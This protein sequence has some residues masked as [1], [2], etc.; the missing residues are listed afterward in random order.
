MYSNE[1]QCKLEKQEIHYS[2]VTAMMVC[3]ALIKD[4]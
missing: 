2:Y 1:M 3:L 4:E